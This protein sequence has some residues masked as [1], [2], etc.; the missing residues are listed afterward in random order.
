MKSIFI[1]LIVLYQRLISPYFPASCRFM[2]TCSE[3][4]KE[5]LEEH[6]LLKGTY[7]SVKRI[8]KCHPIGFLGGSEGYDPVPKEK[9]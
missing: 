8:G 2:P 4:A 1:F 7:L 9:K 3:Y 6:G 5:A